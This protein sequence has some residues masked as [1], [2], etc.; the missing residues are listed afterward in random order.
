MPRPNRHILSPY[1][2]TFALVALA[3]LIRQ[4]LTPWL[5]HD[6]PYLIFVFPLLVAG[7]YFG[8]GPSLMVTAT[9][10]VLG[11]LFSLGGPVGSVHQSLG[12][13]I[14]IMVGLFVSMASWLLHR[15][16]ANV[17]LANQRAMQANHYK[18]QFLTVLGHELRNPLNG[19]ALGAE[20]LERQS[21]GNTKHAELAQMILRQTG[22]MRKLID[23]MLDISR[24][25]QGK[26]KLVCTKVHLQ[27]VIDTCIEQQLGALQKNGQTL[28]LNLPPAPVVVWGDQSRLVQVLANLLTNASKYSG[29]NSQIEVRLSQGS[30]VE[31]MVRDNGRGIPADKLPLL[32]EPFMQI[33]PANTH[34]EG[35]L[36]LGLP[37]ARRLA[38]LHG[39]SL[40]ASSPGP[41]Q[42]AAFTLRLPLQSESRAGSSQA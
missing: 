2:L 33:D 20:I 6:M 22:L 25:D 1:G 17:A 5:G 36:G 12:V 24:I 21:G 27:E 34:A 10:S 37:T 40:Q 7:F 14:F 19:I 8:A 11:T 23:D 30:E 41:G 38:E 3:A 26:I 9:G 29:L 4:A 16:R 13:G 42:G 39:G 31:L 18:D 28:K 15:S 35:G 32:F